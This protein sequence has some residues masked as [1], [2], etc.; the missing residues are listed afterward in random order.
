M[1]GYHQHTCRQLVSGRNSLC[2]PANLQP[3]RCQPVWALPWALAAAAGGHA[4]ARARHGAHQVLRAVSGKGSRRCCRP[5]LRG[6]PLLAPG[7]GVAWSKSR[8]ACRCAVMRCAF[9]EEA[10]RTPLT[11]RVCNCFSL[12]SY[13]ASTGRIL[14]AMIGSANLSGAAWWARSGCQLAPLLVAGTRVIWAQ[15][16]F[17]QQCLSRD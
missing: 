17:Q 13:E 4:G 10:I 8:D 14:W 12:L 11:A 15:V 3:R 9:Q 16:Q 2:R 7:W 1:P 6:V 5:L